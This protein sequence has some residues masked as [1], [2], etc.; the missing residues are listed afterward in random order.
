M[1]IYFIQIISDWRAAYVSLNGNKLS[2]APAN[3]DSNS[4]PVSPSANSKYDLNKQQSLFDW[5]VC[6]NCRVGKAEDISKKGDRTKWG[7]VFSVECDFKEDESK[8]EIYF[9]AETD[10]IGADWVHAVYD[11]RYLVF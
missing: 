11:A 2:G 6:T 5:P 9:V 8:K 1:Q 3:L 10:Q 4:N 7:F